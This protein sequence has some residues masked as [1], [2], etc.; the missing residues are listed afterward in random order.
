[1]PRSTATPSTTLSDDTSNP[2]GFPPTVPPPA[3]APGPAPSPMPAPSPSPS[4]PTQNSRGKFLINSFDKTDLDTENPLP[5][6]GIPYSQAK[7]P[8]VY[9]AT[10]MRTTP[11]RGYFAS[12]GVAASKF[13]QTWSSKNT[14][15][16]FMQKYI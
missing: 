2:P 15:L 7:D 14:Y 5:N 12:A 1:M 10:T 11:T 9:P 8:T 6:G 13:Y 16:D 3:P 4:L